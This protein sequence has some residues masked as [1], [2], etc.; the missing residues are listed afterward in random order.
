M[1]VENAT[2]S[3]VRVLPILLTV[4]SAQTQANGFISKLRTDVTTELEGIRKVINEQKSELSLGRETQTNMRCEIRQSLENLGSVMKG[5]QQ[6]CESAGLQMTESFDRQTEKQENILTFLQ[7]EM[8]RQ[9]KKREEEITERESKICDLQQ[10]L[11]LST[12]AY[13]SRVT[14]MRHSI[15][16]SNGVANKQLQDALSA[17]HDTLEKGFQK[18]KADIERSLS[19]SEQQCAKLQA[20][21]EEE[22]RKLAVVSNTLT[23]TDNSQLRQSLVDERQA[24]ISLTAKLTQYELAAKESSQLHDRWLRDIQAIDALRGQ[25]KHVTE[26]LPYVNALGGQLQDMVTMNNMMRTTAGY[27]NDERRWVQEQLKS[28][29]Q[30]V[31]ITIPAP[32]AVIKLSQT[33]LGDLS[34]HMPASSNREVVST[35]PRAQKE[36]LLPKPE[37]QDSQ[38]NDQRKVHVYSPAVGIRSPSPAMTIQEE[39]QRHREGITPRS[40]LKSSQSSSSQEAF[41]EDLPPKIPPNQSQYNRPV[42]S[43][44]VSKGTGV[45]DAMV[46]QIRAHLLQQRETGLITVVD[47]QKTIQQGKGQSMATYKRKVSTDVAHTQDPNVKRVKAEESSSQGVNDE[48]LRGG[49][50]ALTLERNQM[51]RIRHASI[52]TYSRKPSTQ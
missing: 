2:D 33:E 37:S 13:A 43:Q 47:F 3:I 17:I 41:N 35:E 39:Q 27:L 46:K 30:S 49:A 20:Q 34:A 7:A 40:I 12:D 28:K 24:V 4:M 14:S 10:K 29:V 8:T 52:K 11:Q 15:S 48:A 44:P 5:T 51:A 31:T 26:R 42:M 36:D 18:E 1:T 50:R 19:Q 16:N 32:P 23:N 21:V 38:A 25:L 22:K 6:G 9:F 45:S